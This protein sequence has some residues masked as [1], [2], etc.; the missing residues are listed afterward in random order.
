[1]QDL[2]IRPP[3]ETLDHSPLGKVGTNSSPKWFSQPYSHELCTEFA[4]LPTV[5]VRGLDFYLS[6]ECNDHC[7]LITLPI[8]PKDKS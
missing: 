2:V 5:T 3:L 7:G 6:D 8:V 1:M 4:S